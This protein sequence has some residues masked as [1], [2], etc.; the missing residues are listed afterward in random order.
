MS[1]D[2]VV[3]DTSII[4]DLFAGDPLV[5]DAVLKKRQVF[6]AVPSLGELY[7]GAF[8]SVRR[9]ENIEQIEEMLGE[10]PVL[11]CD[12]GTARS[13]GQVKQSLR[14]QGKQIPEN[15]VWIA[16]LS[17]QHSLALMTRDEHFKWVD[18]LSLDFIPS[19]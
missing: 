15:D 18:G 7:R 1:P 12:V 9:A 5:A 17:L 6:L 2:R 8:G 13:Y 19:P 16:A 3:L 4:V 14:A 11:N 10:M